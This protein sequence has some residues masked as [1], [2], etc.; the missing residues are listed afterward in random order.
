MQ[1]VELIADLQAEGWRVVVVTGRSE[2]DQ[3]A[4]AVRAGAE[5]VFLKTTELARFL[6]LIEQAV[7]GRVL[8]TSRSGAAGPRD[9]VGSRRRPA[10][11]TG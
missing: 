5:G 10:G 9:T 11:S 8:M 7:A 6:E 4:A 3:L 1:G 2:Q